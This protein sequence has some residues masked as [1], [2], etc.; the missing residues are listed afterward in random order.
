MRRE[1]RGEGLNGALLVI[2]APGN[3]QNLQADE[4]RVRNGAR[5]LRVR[6]DVRSL[7]VVGRIQ[8]QATHANCSKNTALG[9]DARTAPHNI[10]FT[11]GGL[12]EQSPEIS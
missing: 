7:G 6:V 9:V 12:P 11:C 10:R 5:E 8:Y 2:R 1:P 4:L 3:S